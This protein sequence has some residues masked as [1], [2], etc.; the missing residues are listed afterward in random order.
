MLLDITIEGNSYLLRLHKKFLENKTSPLSC[1]QEESPLTDKFSYL[2]YFQTTRDMFG[3]DGYF[4]KESED[5]EYTYFRFWFPQAPNTFPVMRQMIITIYLCTYYVLE[6]VYYA[7]EFFDTNIWKDQS[8]SFTIF[9]GGT[10]LG[11]YSIGGQ[12]YPWFKKTIGSLSE[13]QILDLELYTQ[14]EL[15]RIS[16][17]FSK[18][19][20]RFGQVTITPTSFFIE[21]AINGRWIDWS[22]KRGD[23]KPEEFSSHNIDFRQD[24]ELCFAAIVIIN[25]WLR[26][27]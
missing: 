10:T 27:L 1:F 20:I 6:Q 2:G 17:Y 3:F 21:V 23:D 9:D 13:K 11:G 4:K 8:V 15:D 14:T 16:V 5:A 18:E 26:K 12:L 24:Q 25:T 22:K 7:K 19:K